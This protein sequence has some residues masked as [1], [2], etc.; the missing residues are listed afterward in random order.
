MAA[1]ATAER[2][3]QGAQFRLLMNDPAPQAPTTA[4]TAGRGNAVLDE[5]L[6]HLAD[7]VAER[8][9]VRLASSAPV[10]EDWLDARRA[11]EY[12][13][14]HRDTIRRLAAERFPMLRGYQPPD[15]TKISAG[16][17]WE[18]IQQ[19]WNP[20]TLDY[21]RDKPLVGLKEPYMHVV[22]VRVRELRRGSHRRVLRDEDGDLES[23]DVRPTA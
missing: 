21:C 18:H 19:G 3:S 4:A 2:A 1:Y 17:R 12:L 13:G 20:T 22:L 16:A 23:R 10:A 11:A 9:A 15:I 5:L 7:L 14:V 6:D 8:L